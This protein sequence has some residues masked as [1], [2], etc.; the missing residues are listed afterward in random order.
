M[1]KEVY[2]M[3]LSETFFLWMRGLQKVPRRNER[4]LVGMQVLCVWWKRDIPDLTRQ[5][6]DTRA[7]ESILERIYAVLVHSRTTPLSREYMR[8]KFSLAQ[9]RTKLIPM[10]TILVQ[11]HSSNIEHDHN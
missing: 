4:N 9:S 6:I 1:S 3:A 7:T 10:A 5:T 8:W 11:R 2:R